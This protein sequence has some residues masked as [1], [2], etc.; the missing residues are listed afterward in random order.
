MLSVGEPSEEKNKPKLDICLTTKFEADQRF[1]IKEIKPQITKRTSGYFLKPHI[2][3]GFSKFVF[4]PRSH[5]EEKDEKYK[6]LLNIK[7]NFLHAIK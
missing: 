4:K 7:R 2:D 6:R 5:L 3:E 1:N